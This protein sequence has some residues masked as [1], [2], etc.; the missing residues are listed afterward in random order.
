MGIIGKG[1]YQNAAR[2]LSGSR[3]FTFGD[4]SH[5]RTGRFSYLPPMAVPPKHNGTPCN[6]CLLTSSHVKTEY[7][8]RMCS[9]RAN[10]SLLIE[11]RMPKKN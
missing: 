2:I 7:V 5:S 1:Q 3:D 11:I 9:V 4:T 6:A 10:L 8:K